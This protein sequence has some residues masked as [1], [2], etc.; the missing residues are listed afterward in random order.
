MILVMAVL[1]KVTQENAYV[2]FGLWFSL[3]I[4]FMIHTLNEVDCEDVEFERDMLRTKKGRQKYYYLINS[5]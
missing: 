5:Q 4:M 2:G 3:A 1:F